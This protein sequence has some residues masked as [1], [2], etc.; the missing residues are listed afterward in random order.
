MSV[1]FT[2]E[3]VPRFVSIITVHM[4]A[5]VMKKDSTW[6]RINIYVKVNPCCLLEYE[7]GV[8][9]VISIILIEL[10][11][12]IILLLSLK[13]GNTNPSQRQDSQQNF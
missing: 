10:N 4:N 7:L 12:K 11:Q 9:Y 5:S 6:P 3:T 2:M 13:K 1:H 8:Y